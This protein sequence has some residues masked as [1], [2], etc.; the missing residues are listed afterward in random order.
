MYWPSSPKHLPTQA[1]TK[2]GIFFIAPQLHG[3][4]KV[5]D[6]GSIYSRIGM[7]RMSNQRGLYIGNS[8]T[9]HLTN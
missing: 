7:N 5:F 2:E 4:G 1:R 3:V 9:A 8:Q 6:M